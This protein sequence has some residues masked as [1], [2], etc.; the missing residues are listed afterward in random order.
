MFLNHI[1]NYRAV[2]ILGVVATHALQNFHWP[3]ESLVFSGLN[4][5]FNETSIWFVFIAGFLFQHLSG[6]FK[7]PK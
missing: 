7:F 1:H 2:A 4:F 6:K 5:I 3:S